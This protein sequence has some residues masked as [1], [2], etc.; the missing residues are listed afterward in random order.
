MNEEAIKELVTSAQLVAGWSTYLYG[1]D[2]NI[3]KYKEELQK[4]VEFL[5]TKKKEPLPR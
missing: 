1:I 4:A 2:Y 5:R 3:N